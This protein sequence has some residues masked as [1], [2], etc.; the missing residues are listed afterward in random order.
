MFVRVKTI[1]CNASREELC[2]MCIRAEC[3]SKAHALYKNVYY[4]H[5]STRIIYIFLNIIECDVHVDEFLK[6]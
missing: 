2:G 4:T 5:F 6:I 1:S 3:M